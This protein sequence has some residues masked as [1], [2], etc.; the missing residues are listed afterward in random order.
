MPEHRIHIT[1]SEHGYE[2][3]NG[4][5]FLNGFMETHPEVGPSVSQSTADGTLS[6]TLSL[7]AEDANEAFERSRRI[8]VDGAYASGL[9]V[10]QIV[11]VEVSLVPAEEHEPEHKPEPVPA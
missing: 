3:E 5:R 10:T 2:L 6:V 11:G 7:D 8:F 4:E 9:N 1:V